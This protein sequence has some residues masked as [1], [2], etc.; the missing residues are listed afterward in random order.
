[1]TVIKD[2]GKQREFE[3]GAVRDFAE[4]KGRCD[5]LPLDIVADLLPSETIYHLDR[6]SKEPSEES[7]YEAIKCYAKEAELDV[8]SLLI[9]AAKQY[10]DGAK[11]YGEN[12]WKNGMPCHVLLDSGIRHYLKWRKGD[13]DEPHDRAFM[14]NMLGLAWTMRNLPELNDLV[15][16][17][18]K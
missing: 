16:P 15:R 3:T 7:I 5:L 10:E 1:M 13:T 12:N 2:S 8:E 6:L 11:K 4:G 9:E 18:H 14:W 17:N